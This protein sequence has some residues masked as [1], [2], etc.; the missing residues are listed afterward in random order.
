MGKLWVNEKSY[1]LEV[2]PEAPLLW[3]LRDKIGLKGTKYGCGIGICGICMAHINGKPV[4]TCVMPVGEAMGQKV[5]TIEGLTANHPVI[6][7]W[8]A[9]QVPQCGYCQPG[10]V[11]AAVA[12]LAN[13]TSPND[14]EVAAVMSG[15]LCRCGYM[16]RNTG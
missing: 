15:I 13:N 11:M 9:E 8:I 12:L 5:T 2:E 6:Q 3:V 4:R 1:E 14:S 7:A 16:V 10:Q